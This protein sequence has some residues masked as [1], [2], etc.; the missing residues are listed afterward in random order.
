[1][2]KES[3]DIDI[4]LDDMFGKEF[5]EMISKHQEASGE[6]SKNYGVVAANNEQSKHLETAIV[7]LDG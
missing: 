1:M 3:D 5:A 4:A 2:G 6:K 7:R